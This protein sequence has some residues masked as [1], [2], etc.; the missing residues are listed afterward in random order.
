M[1]KQTLNSMINYAPFDMIGQSE[2]PIEGRILEELGGSGPMDSFQLAMSID[3]EYRTV[4]VTLSKM[5]RCGRIRVVEKK[6]VPCGRSR[7]IWSL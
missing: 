6:K 4:A 5:K 2:A 7:N 1:P 3:V